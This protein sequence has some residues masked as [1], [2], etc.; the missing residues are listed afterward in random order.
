MKNNINIDNGLA[1]SEVTC[2]FEDHRGILWLGTS[3]GLSE[4]NSVEFKNYFGENGLPSRFIKSICEDENNKLY[5]ATLEGLVFKD[6]DHFS[7]PPNLPVEL[8]TRVNKIYLSQQEKLYVLT[9]KFGVWVK[10]KNKFH[11]INLENKGNDFTP[12]SIT[13][14]QNGDIL[15][16]TRTSGIY[17]L[18]NDK[19]RQVIFEP[20]Y[21]KYPVVDITE[22]NSG[23]LYIALQGFGLV[24]YDS[25]NKKSIIITSKNGLPSN[26]INDLELDSR[27]MLFVATTNGVAT[28]DKNKITKIISQQNG[29]HNEFI[30]KI[31]S[32]EE[33]TFLFLSE[34]GGF[35]IYQDNAFT[36]YN[37]NTGLLH[38]NVWRIKE[39]KDGSIC[40]LTDEG[41]SL[42]K[43]NK[44]RS[45]TTKNGLG[46]NLA[47][48]L[49]EAQNGD[50]YV[51][52]FSDGVNLI[53]ND[54]IERINQKKGMFQNTTCTIEEYSKDTLFFI[55]R[56]KGIAVYDGHKII[57]TL[58]IEEGLPN[59][60]ILSSLKKKDGT[61]LVSIEKEGLYKYENKKF[62]RYLDDIKSCSIWSIFEDEDGSLYLGTND[63]GLIKH[64]PNGKIDTINVK[65]GMSNNCVVSV[66]G[67][68]NGN[69][70]AGTDKGLNIIKFTGNGKFMIRQLF[71]QS[72]LANSE[73]NQGA[74]Y[75]DKSGNIWMGTI[76]GVTR[77]NPEKIV[78][79]NNRIPIVFTSVGI[80]DKEIPYNDSL[81][82][83][84]LKY[85]ENDITFRFVGIN[86]LDPQIVKYR[87]K[88]E[89]TDKNWIINKNNEV[90]YSKLPPG[91]YN[92]K[93]AVSDAWG[94]W[95][96]PIDIFF[97]IQKPFWQTWWFTAFI[98]LSI[99][100]IVYAIM[101]Y[102][103]KNALRLEKLRGKISADL[104]DEIG[105]GLSEI[106]I[107]SEL[108]KYNNTFDQKLID[109]LNQIGDSTR[110]LIKSLS[111]I[112]WIVDPGKESLGDLI[113]RIQNTYQ[114]VF[115]QANINLKINNIEQ[116][117]DLKL[118]LEVRQNLYL[119]IKEAVNNSL[120]YSKCKNIIINI[121]KL[122]KHLVFEI[123]DDGIGLNE[124][125]YEKGNGLYNMKKRAETIK[126]EFN[127]ESNNHGTKIVIK[128]PVK[129]K[130]LKW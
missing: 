105:S 46:D 18:V 65:K 67:D 36:T 19:L 15:I 92:F 118:H 87:Y 27:N 40:F 39:L 60:N 14:K 43:N 113:N 89:G 50:L 44:F 129:D 75:K 9:E 77:I 33:G 4:W 22:L 120:K 31:Y 90:R 121:K 51:S 63:K 56:S 124:G 123:I 57:D 68:N 1:Y 59:L 110:R 84:T 122:K 94:V 5:I 93:V 127:I 52:T 21:K 66:I 74:V 34:G 108:L 125:D 42:L 71:K 130:G 80:L 45:I 104:H 16:G 126:A 103:L 96:K 62:T 106:S 69:I 88:L 11:R 85:Y 78:S 3:S 38:D 17:E 55:T 111:D 82:N 26:H 53:T 6:N 32:L 23:S 99:I 83:L 115:F 41:I 101:N 29:L 116:L 28:V 25:E 119:I 7:F 102:R 47:V 114:E 48:T 24:L 10:E 30:S 128:I 81:N 107:L 97:M 58:G 8:K 72:G 49:F 12:L 73:C 98:L 112:I 61:I 86:Y 79:K 70:Y 37:K 117:N 35:Y 2:A 76:G 54:H 13:E 95:S 91:E 100:F 64:Y 20:V 109:G